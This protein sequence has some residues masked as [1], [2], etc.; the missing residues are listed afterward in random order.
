MEFHGLFHGALL[1]EQGCD[2]SWVFSKPQVE[3]LIFP[4]LSCISAND[5][6]IQGH[7]SKFNTF[8]LHYMG[9][10]L[11]FARLEVLHR[12]LNCRRA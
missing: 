5:N 10:S 4:I 11:R 7:V 9:I 8:L 1:P 6:E 3:T 2:D 12:L